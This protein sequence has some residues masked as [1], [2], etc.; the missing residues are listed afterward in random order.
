MTTT[1]TIEYE[2]GAVY[3]IPTTIP[4]AGSALHHATTVDTVTALVDTQHAADHPDCDPNP[5]T[6]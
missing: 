2:C 5:E 1:V 3:E 4:A 6:R